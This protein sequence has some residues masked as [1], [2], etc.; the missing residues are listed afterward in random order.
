MREGSGP[1]QA[2]IAAANE[3]GAGRLAALASGAV[4]SGIRALPVKIACAGCGCVVEHGVIL[5]PCDSYPDCCCRD[6]PV[7]A[8]A[9]K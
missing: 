7:R 3:G 9:S 6:V 8:S 2:R 1:P 4:P 5:T